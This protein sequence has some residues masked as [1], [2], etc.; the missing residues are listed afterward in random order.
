MYDTFSVVHIEIQNFVNV[1]QQII[2]F[3]EREVDYERKLD[4]VV[5]FLIRDPTLVGPVGVG[6]G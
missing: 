4:F 5:A 3:Q 1:Q 6:H 2:Y